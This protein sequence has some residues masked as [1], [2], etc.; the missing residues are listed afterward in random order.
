MKGIG[1]EYNGEGSAEL[2]NNIDTLLREPRVASRS[3]GA[4]QKALVGNVSHEDFVEFSNALHQQIDTEF[5]L[6]NLKWT[7]RKIGNVTFA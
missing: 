7:A 2:F 4:I 3:M 6:I 1:T 5:A